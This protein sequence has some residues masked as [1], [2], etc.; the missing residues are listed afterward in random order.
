MKSK[1]VEYI[2][3]DSASNVSIS[4]REHRLQVTGFDT[5]SCQGFILN[6]IAVMISFLKTRVMQC[7]KSQKRLQSVILIAFLKLH[8]RRGLSSRKK[9][10]PK[11]LKSK[12]GSPLRGAS[13]NLNF[14][15]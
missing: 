15:G 11:R 13:I 10:S 7:N 6:F 1:T 12:P 4:W 14:R 9:T 5:D 8:Q 2:K 3:I